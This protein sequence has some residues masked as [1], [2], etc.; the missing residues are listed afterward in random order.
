MNIDCLVEFIL[1]CLANFIGLSF[2]LFVKIQWGHVTNQ[3]CVE[4]QVKP[5]LEDEK[6]VE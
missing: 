1:A 4:N 6:D 5:S 2:A 3:S